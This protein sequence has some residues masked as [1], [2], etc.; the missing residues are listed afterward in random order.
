MTPFAA[1]L[2]FQRLIINDYKASAK[3]NNYKASGSRVFGMQQAAHAAISPKFM[4]IW[5]MACEEHQPLAQVQAG[6]A[7]VLSS[8]FWESSMVCEVIGGI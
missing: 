7:L 4:Q 5:P 6:V 3:H 8:W 1:G 2:L